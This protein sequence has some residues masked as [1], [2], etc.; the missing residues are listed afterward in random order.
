MEHKREKRIE[1]T[2][3]QVSLAAALVLMLIFLAFMVGQGYFLESS[4]LE[5]S[6]FLLNSNDSVL[7]PGRYY[8]EDLDEYC[9]QG[10][11]RA[12]VPHQ[13][14]KQES[15]KKNDQK[16]Q[17]VQRYYAQLKGFG[18]VKAAQLLSEQLKRYH[19]PTL[20]VKRISRTVSGVEQCWYQVITE[21]YTNKDTLSSITKKAQRIVGIKNC[22]M[23]E[24]SREIQKI[25]KER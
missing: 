23:H 7:E 4:I 11:M 16:V 22:V 21:L 3:Q 10:E 8:A 17:H 12:L 2:Q 1:F 14:S 6:Y 9:D 15:S 24:V 18:T 20:I 13:G 19:I 5:H 25:E